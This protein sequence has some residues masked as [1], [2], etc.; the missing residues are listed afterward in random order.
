MFKNFLFH[1][2]YRCNRSSKS[3]VMGLQLGIRT[4][5]YVKVGD[6]VFVGA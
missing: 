4:P 5:G 2:S 1:S 3:P 6:E